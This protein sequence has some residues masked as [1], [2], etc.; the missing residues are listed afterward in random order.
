MLK[1]RGKIL[2]KNSNPGCLG[3]PWGDF[4]IPT[5][6]RRWARSMACFSCHIVL[7]GLK[8]D[9]VP[10]QKELYQNKFR[11]ENYLVYSPT[12]T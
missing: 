10:N 7:E 3:H 9:N 11:I 8:R 4:V 2:K 6:W 12:F 5:G 1:K